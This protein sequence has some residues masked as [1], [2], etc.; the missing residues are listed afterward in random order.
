VYTRLEK[1]TWSLAVAVVFGLSGT[2]A[3]A[4]SFSMSSTSDSVV[5]ELQQVKSRQEETL[6][7]V[8]REFGLGYDQVIK[9]NPKVNR[10]VPGQGT[11]VLLPNLYVLPDAP[12]QGLVINLAELR[13]Y[14]FPGGASTGSVVTF[15]VSIGRMDWKTPLGKASVVAK[16]KDPPW[17]PPASIK[18]EHALDGDPLPDVIPGGTP[19]NP[20]GHYALRLSIPGYLIHGVDERKANGIGMRVT[21]GCIRMYPENVEQ[22]YNMVPVKTPVMLVNQPVKVGKKDGLLYLQ[23]VT[24]LQEDEDSY[25]RLSVQNSLQLIREKAGA[26][27]VIDE[28]K[29]AAAIER[30][31]GVTVVIGK[32]QSGGYDSYQY[33][34]RETYGNSGGSIRNPTPSAVQSKPAERQPW[35]QG[36]DTVRGV[37]QQTPDVSGDYRSKVRRPDG[38]SRQETYQPDRYRGNSGRL[39]TEPSY[40]NQYEKQQRDVSSEYERRMQGILGG[41][42]RQRMNWENSNATDRQ[43]KRERYEN[44]TAITPKVMER[45]AEGFTRATPRRYSAEQYRQAIEADRDADY[46]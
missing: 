20:L 42:S 7:D 8:A 32:Q 21:H 16:E 27:F 24:P 25:F 44:Q 4:E 34:N 43:P 18:R 29:A 33:A 30:G 26:D 1:V 45:D 41:S 12:K 36:G 14:Y 3:L 23:V 22:V 37:D 40:P 5:G 28:R 38:Y 31:D 17:R 9:A 11:K 19:D 6:I 15:P 46:Y 39:D 35:N 2:R 10:W 13:M